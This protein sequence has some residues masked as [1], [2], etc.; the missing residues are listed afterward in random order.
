[1]AT[2][3][4]RKTKYVQIVKPPEPVNSVQ[5]DVVITDFLLQLSTFKDIVKKV[6]GAKQV[7]VFKRDSSGNITN[8]S[9]SSWEYRPS[10]NTHL[11]KNVEIGGKK[12][13]QNLQSNLDF[14]R[15]H[16]LSSYVSKN[17][18]LLIKNV[19]HHYFLF[20]FEQNEA[21][22]DFQNKFIE[23][24]DEHIDIDFFNQ[25]GERDHYL[26]NMTNLIIQT[27]SKKDPYTGGHTKRVGMFAEWISEEMGLGSDFKK[28][29][30][31]A[32]IIHDV[33][34]I[35]I[36]DSVLK[37]D[38]PL[39]DEEFEIMKKH[40]TIGADILKRIPGFEN[41]CL[42]VS[43]HHERP[44]GKGYPNG[45]KGREIPLIA[46]I[47]SLSDAFDAMISTRPYRKAIPPYEA[48]ETLKAFKGTQFDEKVFDA[49]ERAFMKSHMAR[50]HMNKVKKV[51]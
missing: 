37:K 4:K 13:V 48:Y 44:D 41:I 42:G 32:A 12:A 10:A 26:E 31:Y 35:G 23:S 1:M 8:L 9:D 2:I 22:T 30:Y 29:A 14:K 3:R 25:D 40:P 47:V 24:L 11:F 15:D 45:L 18:W 27:I 28:E 20:E 50:N 5:H 34:K 21:L 38:A 39:T 33:G 46:S 36:P 51:G 17:S 7:F 6:L 19:K 16:I 43:L 49:F